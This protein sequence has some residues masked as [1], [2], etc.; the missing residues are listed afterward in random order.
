[1]PAVMAEAGRHGEVRQVG[2]ISNDLDALEKLMRTLARNSVSD[3]VSDPP[4]S[5]AGTQRLP[6]S[7]QSLAERLRRL[8]GLL[9]ANVSVANRCADVLVP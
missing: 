7:L 6:L 9:I 8:P 2:T 1:M 4:V 3:P 5:F